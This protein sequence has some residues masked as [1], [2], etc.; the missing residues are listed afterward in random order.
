[1]YIRSISY[2]RMF[3]K[4]VGRPTGKFKWTKNQNKTQLET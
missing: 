4:Q 1:M 2:A 3:I